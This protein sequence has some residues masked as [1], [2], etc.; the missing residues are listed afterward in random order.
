[1]WSQGQARLSSEYER[2]L[3]Y[4][5]YHCGLKPKEIVRY[6]PLEWS[7][8]HEVTRLRRIILERLMKGLEP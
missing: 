6:C 7:D 8:V 5:L 3:A 4:L 1:M 2:G